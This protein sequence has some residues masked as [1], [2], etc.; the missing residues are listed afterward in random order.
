M[1]GRQESLAFQSESSDFV[2]KGTVQPV[3]A[4]WSA[5]RQVRE[6]IRGRECVRA[7][8]KTPGPRA[9]TC[10]SDGTTNSR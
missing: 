1:F 10:S 3:W 8:S 5:N 7:G 2:L 9:G 6:V 4:V